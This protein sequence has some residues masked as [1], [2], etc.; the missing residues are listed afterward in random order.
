MLSFEDSGAVPLGSTLIFFVLLLFF[1][2]YPFF[3]S[4]KTSY[5]DAL[6]LPRSYA[7][8]KTRLVHLELNPRCAICGSNKNL[9]VHHILSFHEHPEL[10]CDP[11]NLMTLCENKNLNCHFVFGHRMRWSD[12]NPKLK[13]QV[14][15]MRRFLNYDD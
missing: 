14:E 3:V 13:E 1:A 12:T 11:D 9:I 4:R 6:G 10:E 5:V 15:I 2:F 8:R 7:W